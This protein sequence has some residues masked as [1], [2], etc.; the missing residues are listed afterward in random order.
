MRVIDNTK[1][2]GNNVLIILIR[3]E[4]EDKSDNKVQ[5]CHNPKVSLCKER[6]YFQLGFSI[7]TFRQLRIHILNCRHCCVGFLLSVCL[8][9]VS[10]W[11][12]LTLI[13]DRCLFMTGVD[14]TGVDNTK[15]TKNLVIT[16]KEMKYIDSYGT[17][18]PRKEKTP[19]SETPRCSC[20]YIFVWGSIIFLTFLL[21]VLFG[22]VIAHS[23]KVDFIE[24]VSRIVPDFNIT[25]NGNLHTCR[26]WT[27]LHLVA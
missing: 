1:C 19:T 17:D 10:L 26:G 22:E 8:V 20:C 27:G 18:L 14:V 15:P 4:I 25:F 5:H 6:Q 24:Q 7:Y 12:R 23:R 3:V 16:Q 13:C 11:E 9:F 2:L 21:G